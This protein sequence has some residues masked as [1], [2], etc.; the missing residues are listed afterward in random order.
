MIAVPDTGL[1]I[2]ASVEELRAALRSHGT[3]VLTAPP[4]SGKTTVVPLRLVDEP[5]VEGRRIVVLEPRRL[6]TRAA[7]R[8]MADLAGE[9]VGE[10]IGYVTRDERRTSSRTR[11]EVI[12]EGVLTR[13]L[14]RDA[15][16][17][18]TAAVIFDELH[19]RN[20]QTDLGMALALD[21][22]ATLRPDLRIAAMSAT[23]DTDRVAALIGGEVAAPVVASDARTYPV[24]VR[25]E[26][27]QRG[28][29]IEDHAASVVRQAI[30]DEGG[31]VLVFLPGMRA[32]KRCRDQ[33][34]DLGAD[35]D[36]RLLHGSIPPEDQDAALVPS[37]PGHRKIVLSTDIAETS[38]T[39]EGVRIVVDTG[40]ARAPRLD[41]RHGMTRLQTIPISRASAEQRAGRAGR[42]EP[43]VAYRL[44]SKL[45]HGGRRPHIDPELLQ[46]DLAGLAL[47]LAAW[48][49]PDPDDLRFLDRP[50]PKAYTEA[51]RLLVM[52]GAVDDDRRLT[53]VGRT[54]VG[55]PLHP[56]LARMVADAGDDQALA[57]VIAALL[58]ER[59]VLHG[60]PDDLPSDLGLRVR[61]VIDSSERHPAASIRTIRRV[62]RVAEDLRR[63]AGISEDVIDPD[64]SG[65][66]LALAF[67]DRLA[68][69]RGSPGR[70]Q[71]RTGTTAWL[72][73]RDPLAV[74]SFLVPADL[75][76]KRKDAR[77]RVAAPIDPDDVAH[78]FAHEVTEVSSFEWQGDRLWQRTD[79]KLGGLALDSARR[80]PEPGE[81][82][83]AEIIRRLVHNELRDLAWSKAASEFR[84]RVEFLHRHIGEPW[85]DASLA[86]LAE[87]ADEWLVPYL[88]EPSGLDDVRRLDVLQ[89]LRNHVG[90]P[91]AMEVESLVPRQIELPSGRRATVDYSGE[92]P[93][94]GAR[95]QEFFGAA[96]G[97]RIAGAPVLLM[98]LSPADRPIQITADLGGFWTGSWSDVRK[99]MAGRYPKHRWPEDPLTEQPGR[100]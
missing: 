35:I 9:P 5:W 17:P 50:P 93:T 20:L 27:P 90:Y 36:I 53:A 85:P 73:D 62:R 64:R 67:P 12:T 98:L 54:M 94:V 72:S 83:T 56:R 48:G 39:V 42:T 25:W 58:E 26:R 52:L 45:E 23:I 19:E 29:W 84:S 63:R 100:R 74:E 46:V 75:D 41:L 57:C 21:A 24:D 38:L 71:L 1:P 16:L 60:H 30:R 92:Q 59:D 70:F 68:V 11:I 43:G 40:Q 87:R 28:E 44:W 88:G 69:R 51:M 77:I 49:T 96:D 86:A 79:R 89:L 95:V 47:E 22:R 10:T 15:E 32:I 81:Q 76:G 65:P 6:A 99:D 78:R 14:Q 13:R 61:L 4:G 80:R 97:P 3:V 18:N 2:E 34:G 91:A 7:A 33:L 55:L 82:T 8:R 31:D 66:V 37:P